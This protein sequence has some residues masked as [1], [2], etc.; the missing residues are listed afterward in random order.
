MRLGLGT[1]QLGLSYGVTNQAGKP[2]EEMI[3]KIFNAA[4]AGNFSIIDTASSYGDSEE[5]IGKHLPKEWHPDIVTKVPPLKGLQAKIVDDFLKLSLEK[6]GRPISG[7]LIH[8]AGDLLGKDG[9]EILK[10]LYAAKEQGLTLGVGFSAYTAEEIDKLLEIIDP[11]IVQL[12]ISVADQR[13]IDSGHIA[14]LIDMGVQ[15]HC[16]SAFLQGL[17]LID[18]EDLPEYFH[19]LKPV[20]EILSKWS[21]ELQIDRL[22]LC[23]AFFSQLGGIDSLIM[24]ASSVSEVIE[25]SDAAQ[26][27]RICDVLPWNEIPKINAKIL[28]PSHWPN[29]DLILGSFRPR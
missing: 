6:L 11:D 7:L 29:R 18:P 4:H 16:R 10:R 3:S 19:E 1:A 24:G 2:D 13:L 8:H 15:V 25:L 17:L 12:P 14:K 27:A 20:L 26:R 5:M 9:P 21:G 22:S 23:I 28:N